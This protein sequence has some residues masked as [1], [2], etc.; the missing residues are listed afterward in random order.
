MLTQ[1][2][3]AKMNSHGSTARRSRMTPLQSTQVDELLYLPQF[4]C[5]SKLRLIIETPPKRYHTHAEHCR[6]LHLS[7]ADGR[8]LTALHDITWQGYLARLA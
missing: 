1:Q 3:L 6:N 7:T 5:C 4:I 2:M 8:E